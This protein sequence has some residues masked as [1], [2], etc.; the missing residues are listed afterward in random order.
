[1]KTDICTFMKI[2]INSNLIEIWQELRVLYMK[3]NICTFMKI[4]INSNL[5]EIRQELRVLYMKTDICTFMKIS[6]NSNLIE[7]WQ[8]L[9]VLY[10]KTDICTFMKI[11]RWILFRMKNVSDKSYRE[12]QN[13]HF[14]FNN[15]FFLSKIVPFM[16]QCG[17]KTVAESDRPHMTKYV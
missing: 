12:N 1:M 16:R 5:I 17:E 10:M 15:F 4:S 3:T 14:M 2:S 11:S 13:T 8:E 7:I 9:R 6:I